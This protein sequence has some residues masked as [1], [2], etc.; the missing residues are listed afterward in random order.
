MIR[1]GIANPLYAG[2]IPVRSSTTTE[3]TKMSRSRRKTPIMGITTCRSEKKDKRFNNRKLRRATKVAIGKDKEI[4]P[5]MDDVS[6]A[7]TMGK[8]G[9]QY[10]NLSREGASKWMRK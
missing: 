9:R 8:D 2:L 3:T 10:I 1:Q 4:L 7:W 6:N 5:G